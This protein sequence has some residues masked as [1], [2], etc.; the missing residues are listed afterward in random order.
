MP[1]CQN[2]NSLG[3]D[4]G[5]IKGFF[6]TT[7]HSFSQRKSCG[8]RATERRLNDCGAPY[9]LAQLRSSFGLQDNRTMTLIATVAA[10][11]LEVE[12]FTTPSDVW[13]QWRKLPIGTFVIGRHRIPAV[14]KRSARGLQFFAT[15]PGRVPE[16]DRSL[17]S[18]WGICC[19]AG[20]GCAL[21]SAG[22]QQDSIHDDAGLV[23]R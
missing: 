13:A 21:Q 22:E 9:C 17:P 23:H 19:V 2:L 14:L 11:G 18:Q 3:R 7:K 16:Q 10:T 1:F 4:L 12:S 8:E 6:R 15:A 20:A 5:N